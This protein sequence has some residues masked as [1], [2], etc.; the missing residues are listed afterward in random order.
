MNQLDIAKWS[1]R[2]N[3]EQNKVYDHQSD[4]DILALVRGVVG[5]EQHMFGPLAKAHK[6]ALIPRDEFARLKVP[7]A[8]TTEF[9][10]CIHDFT[11]LPCQIHRDCINCDEQVC[12]K[13]DQVREANIRRHR[14]ETRTLL[15]D[16]QAADAEKY[17]GANRWV[18]H[19]QITLARLD[20][21]CS[22][23]DD[24]SVPAGSVIQPSGV[25]PASR[26]RQA[27]AQRDRLQASTES[28]VQE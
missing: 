4:R 11:M 2:V 12:I 1:G 15:A 8:H 18:E 7:T 23:L 22:I 13:G 26:L 17:A 24:P 28:A 3:V 16:A 6:A 5:D 9:G 20:Q 27:A 10:Y 25:I 21:L 14:E 19:Q